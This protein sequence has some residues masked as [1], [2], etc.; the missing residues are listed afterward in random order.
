MK[1]NKGE[2]TKKRKLQKWTKK[3]EI[4]NRKIICFISN[5][6]YR[7]RIKKKSERAIKC[8][9]KSAN[10]GVRVDFVKKKGFF[11]DSDLIK[12]QNKI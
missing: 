12:I 4:N 6:D 2:V 7:K 11:L 3:K 9:K 5:R 10:F 1:E 8:L